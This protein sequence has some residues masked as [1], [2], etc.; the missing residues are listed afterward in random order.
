MKRVILLMDDNEDRLQAMR[1][2]VADSYPDYEIVLI[3]NAPDTIE[4]LKG[5]ITSVALMSLDHGLGPNRERDGHVFDP[6]SLCVSFIQDDKKGRSSHEKD[7]Q[8]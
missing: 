8:N 4:W 1:S 7:Y 5:N 6:M 3:D 2:V